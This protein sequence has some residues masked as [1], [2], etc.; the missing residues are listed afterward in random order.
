[1]ESAFLKTLYVLFVIE[2]GTRRIRI[3]DVTAYRWREGQRYVLRD[4]DGRSVSLAEAK[5]IV[6]ERY[7]FPSQLR[8]ARPTHTARPPG[9][10][11][12]RSPSPPIRPLLL[13]ELAVPPEQRVGPNQERGLRCLRPTLGSLRR[14]SPR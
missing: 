8:R 11:G 7:V 6:A 5:R 2:L 10:T 9:R 12:R 1:V 4:V 13:H 14:A 3:A